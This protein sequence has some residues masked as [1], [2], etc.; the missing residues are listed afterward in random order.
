MG[1]YNM[2]TKNSK[3]RKNKIAGP[4]PVTRFKSTTVTVDRRLERR[5]R[6]R[7]GEFGSIA[8][9]LRELI[10]KDLKWQN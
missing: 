1:L 9:Y 10:Y 2:K 8:A 4:W 5:I 7:I 6:E 3:Q